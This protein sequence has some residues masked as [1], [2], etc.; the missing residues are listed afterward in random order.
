MLVGHGKTDGY[1]R[2]SL[3]LEDFSSNALIYHCANSL[4]QEVENVL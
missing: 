3:E 2:R 1:D 4:G